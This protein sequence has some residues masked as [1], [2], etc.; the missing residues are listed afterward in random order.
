[1][2]YF[3]GEQIFEGLLLKEKYEFELMLIM[4][5]IIISG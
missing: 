4:L 3:I 2:F 5:M 1:M